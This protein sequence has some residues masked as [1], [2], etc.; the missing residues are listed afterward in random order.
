MLMMTKTPHYDVGGTIHMV[1]NNQVGFTTPGDRGRTTN[2]CTD[3]AKSIEAPVFHV[4]ADDPEVSFF[5]YNFLKA[6]F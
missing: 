5:A 3:L 1:V 4:N 2:Y 6:H